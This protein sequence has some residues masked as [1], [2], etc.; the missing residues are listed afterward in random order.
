MYS[1]SDI[2]IASAPNAGYQVSLVWE[3]TLETVR[4]AGPFTT[5]TREDAERVKQLLDELGALVTDV[6][7]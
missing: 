2:V 1:S 6:G 7:S 3:V 5:R 4:V